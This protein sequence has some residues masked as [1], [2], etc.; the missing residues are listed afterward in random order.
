MSFVPAKYD[1]EPLVPKRP[2]SQRAATMAVEPDQESISTLSSITG[3]DGDTARRYLRVKQNNVEQAVNALL[4]GEDISKLEQSSIWDESAFTA[5]REGNQNLH[6]L[7]TS[8]APTRGPS[9]APSLGLQQ[10]MSKHDE[11]DELARALA[12]SRGD[13]DM[14]FAQERGVVK[15]D[16]SEVKF[17]PATRDHYDQSQWALV[18]ASQEIVPDAPAHRRKYDGQGPRFLKHLPDGD[19]TP[20]LITICHSIAKLR[21]AFYL[22]DYVKHDYGSEPDWW[23][24]HP[25]PMPRIVHTSDGTSAEPDSD[26]YDELISE[27]QRL[28]AFL[29][30]SQRT[31][32]SIGGI[33][34]SDMIKNNEASSSRPDTLMELFLQGWME[35]AGSRLGATGAI[36]KLFTTTVGTNAAAGMADA[37]MRVVDLTVKP[38]EGTTD[39]LELLDDLLWDTEPNGDEMVDNYIEE[40]ADFIVMRVQHSSQSAKR[41]GLDVP[42]SFHIDKYLQENVEATRGIRQ[43]MMQGKRRVAKIDEIERKLKSWQHPKKSTQVEARQLLNHAIGHFS[44]QNRKA[45]DTADMTNHSDLEHDEPDYYPDVAQKLEQIVASI[46]KK[47]VVLAEEREKTCKAI[48]ELSKA[49]L[50]LQTLET[51]PRYTL[52]GVATKPNITY[53]LYPTEG[54]DRDMSNSDEDTTPPGH[55]WWRVA[56][57][58]SGS[59]ASS[60]RT[61][62]GDFDVLRAVEL[63]H[64]SA[65]LVYG[66]DEACD[67]EDYYKPTVPDALKEFVERDNIQFQQELQ[68]AELPSYNIISNDVGEIPRKSIERTSMDS[69]K[70]GRGDS[71]DEGLLENDELTQQ[72][73]AFGLG[74]EVKPVG[75]DEP[76]RPRT[77]VDEIHLDAEED[78]LPHSN[79]EMVQKPDHQPFVPRPGTGG[80]TAMGGM[81]SQDNGVGG[82]AH[83]E[84]ADAAGPR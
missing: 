45:V 9:P 50:D 38:R 21:E 60:I 62:A 61:R 15:Q 48:S 39:L 43:Q 68:D 10:P 55:Q 20:N 23:R 52:R 37:N 69:L 3:C 63:E 72:H 25:I 16:G 34:Q 42:A 77:P 66:N 47:L 57:E 54:E 28:T 51:H 67:R 31:Y 76:D 29:D 1:P 24:G 2:N 78:I 17:G 64:S 36:K 46:D 6:P 14:P 74:Y 80:D 8:A 30:Y 82:A 56:Y 58:S 65:L 73:H 12:M 26:K 83:V 75:M 19:Y 27:V 81:E 33:T 7:G 32:A 4:D 79:V 59:S 13:V 70:V 53:V 44:G 84:D 49:S 11:D 41:L 71:D 18:P 22:R 35:A 5:D 40:P